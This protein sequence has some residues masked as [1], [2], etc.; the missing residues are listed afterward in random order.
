VKYEGQLR[1]SP[2]KSRTWQQR[3]NR[4]KQAREDA[5]VDI[6][7]VLEPSQED[8]E[9]LKTILKKAISPAKLRK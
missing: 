9:D 6:N 8:L 4:Q 1:N 2:G 3:P 7:N 5:R